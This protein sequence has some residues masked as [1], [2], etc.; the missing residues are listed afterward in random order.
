LISRPHAARS[1]D[2]SFMM[3]EAKTGRAEGADG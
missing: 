3:K 2:S 1:E